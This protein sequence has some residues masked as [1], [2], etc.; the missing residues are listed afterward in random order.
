[1]YK[2]EKEFQSSFKGHCK[3]GKSISR[4]ELL[5]SFRSYCKIGKVTSKKN[6]SG[7]AFITQMDFRTLAF[8]QHNAAFTEKRRAL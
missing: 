5:S 4:K 8:K 3:V 6:Q 1:M 2:I 7:D